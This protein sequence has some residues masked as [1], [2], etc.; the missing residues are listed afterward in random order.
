[1][2]AHTLWQAFV[3]SSEPC[4]W[5]ELPRNIDSQAFEATGFIMSGPSGLLQQKYLAAGWRR[6]LTHSG[7]YDTNSQSQQLPFLA[8]LQQGASWPRQE[9][10]HLMCLSAFVRR[11]YSSSYPMVDAVAMHLRIPCC[12]AAAAACMVLVSSM[13]SS[14][15]LQDPVLN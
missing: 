6:T 10:A 4:T 7:Q 13:A 5:Q 12:T 9:A 11:M 15:D 8:L 3:A 1:M 14:S 2:T